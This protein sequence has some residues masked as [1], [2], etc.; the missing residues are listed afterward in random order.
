[1]EKQHQG[2][3]FKNERL[4]QSQSKGVLFRREYLKNYFLRYEALW[5]QMLDYKLEG[6]GLKAKNIVFRV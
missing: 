6:S 3:H 2:I 5:K 4:L 1:M